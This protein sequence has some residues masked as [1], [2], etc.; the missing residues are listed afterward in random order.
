MQLSY[1][2]SIRTALLCL[3]LAS[4]EILVLPTSASAAK[5]CQ[6]LFRVAASEHA[7]IEFINSLTTGTALYGVVAKPKTFDG[8]GLYSRSVSGGWRRIVGGNVRVDDRGSH[9]LTQLALSK[10]TDHPLAVAVVDNRIVLFTPGPKI[11]STPSI[12]EFGSAETPLYEVGTWQKRFLQPSVPISMVSIVQSAGAS[13]HGAQLVSVSLKF[14]YPQS[15]GDGMTFAFEVPTKLVDRK[16]ILQGRPIVLDYEF[17][18]KADLARYHTGTN[19]N[20]VFSKI[21]LERA[22]AQDLTG[23][24][25]HFAKVSELLESYLKEIL[26]SI[27]GAKSSEKPD[28]AKLAYNITNGQI[29]ENV[30]FRQ[31]IWNA[32]TLRIDQ[33]YDPLKGTAR[34]QSNVAGITI[35]RTVDLYPDG[36]AAIWK[37]DQRNIAVIAGGSLF[38]FIHTSDGY[39]RHD[40]SPSFL[41]NFMGDTLP[42]DFSFIVHQPPPD[43]EGKTT[44]VKHGAIFV[45]FRTETA[46]GLTAMTSIVRFDRYGNSITNV[47]EPYT[48][49][50]NYLPIPMLRA[51][52]STQ[53]GGYVVFDKATPPAKTV[54]AYQQAYDPSKPH[55]SILES[56]VNDLRQRYNAPRAET[57]LGPRLTYAEFTPS[58]D[59]Q[60]PTGIYFGHGAKSQKITGNETERVLGSLLLNAAAAER[61][62]TPA[63]PP[64]EADFRLATIT[65]RWH[66]RDRS[67]GPEF[68]VLTSSQLGVYAIDAKRANGEY[69]YQLVVAIPPSPA[70]QTVYSLEFSRKDDFYPLEAYKDFQ[71]ASFIRGVRENRDLYYLLLVFKKSDGREATYIVPFNMAL[72]KQELKPVM[73]QARALS[74]AELRESVGF[75]ETGMPVILLTPDLAA[76]SQQFAI[77]DLRDERRILPNVERVGRYKNVKFGEWTSAE[78]QGQ[79]VYVK[80]EDSWMPVADVL[81]KEWPYLGRSSAMSANFEAFNDLAARLEAMADP[82]Q[83]ARRFILVVPQALR[84]LIWNFVL[85]RGVPLLARKATP[86]NPSYTPVTDR[87]FSDD[88]RFVD[89]SV[90]LKD[91]GHQHQ[92]LANLAY[93]EKQARRHPDVRQ[94]ALFRADDLGNAEYQ[95]APGN[96][97]FTVQTVSGAGEGLNVSTSTEERAPHPLYLVAAGGPVSL[98][99]FRAD[100]PAAKTS[101]F[102]LATPEDMQR[103]NSQ[104]QVEIENGLLKAFEIREI[105]DPDYP[106]MSNS[107]QQI[108]A[109]P[110]IAEME[111]S[112][113]A[114]EIKIGVDLDQ[115]ASR[116]SVIDFAVSRFSAL[117]KERKSSLFEDFMRFRRDFA[118]ALLS[119]KEVRSTR[120]INKFFIERVLSQVFNIPM[121]L[122]ALPPDDPLKVMAAPDALLRLQDAGYAG[123]FPLKARA[124]NVI[125]AQTRPDTG[126][127]MPSSMMIWGETGSGKTFLFQSIVAMLKLKVYD[128]HDDRS[129]ETAQA[130]HINVGKLADGANKEGNNSDN[131]T[132]DQAIEHLEQF[133]SGPMGYRGFILID[134]VHASSN[135]VKG[136][137]LNWIRTLQEAPDGMYTTASGVKRPVRNIVLMLTFNP[138]ANQKQIASFAKDKERP[139]EEEIL[140]ATLSSEEFPIEGSFLRRWGMVKHFDHMPAG[141]KG[142]ELIKKLGEQAGTLLNAIGRIGLVA[143]EMIQQLV[144]HNETV[145][146]RSFLAAS[147]GTLLEVAASDQRPGNLLMIVPKQGLFWNRVRPESG[148]G[149]TRISDTNPAERIQDWVKENS[150]ILVLDSGVEGRLMFTRLIANSYR[151]PIY[152]SLA[153][154]LQE[155]PRFASNTRVENSVTAPVLLAIR[156]HLHISNDISVSD[157]G[158]YAGQFGL[159]TRAES[160]YFREIVREL[161]GPRRDLIPKFLRSIEGATSMADD[162]GS[163]T[164]VHSRGRSDLLAEGF[165]KNRAILHRRLSQLLRMQDIDARPNPATWLDGLSEQTAFNHR[166]AGRELVQVLWDYLNDAFSGKLAVNAEEVQLDPYAA[167]RLFLYTLDQAVLAMPWAPT[168]QFLLDALAIVSRDQV[169]SQRPGV[170]AFLFSDKQRLVTAT[171]SDYAF[172]ILDSTE[173]IDRIPEATQVDMEKYFADNID[174][175]VRAKR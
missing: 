33:Y 81:R 139:T 104:A 97:L 94:V 54:P 8:E 95:K 109:L 145:D 80:S 75:D 5:A 110:D 44:L 92:I 20:I 34:I 28:E 14:K 60:D 140:L 147:A 32:G 39:M 164:R 112:F 13:K 119:D 11:D 9:L 65:H 155:D 118:L 43:K 23:F 137:I 57:P 61:E 26:K 53:T 132:A 93:F 143:P 48:V 142:P 68:E 158:F 173:I 102:V 174:R 37:D 76:D 129:A 133:L 74:Q 83:P 149:G 138:T 73:V 29:V 126:K 151:I 67:R 19:E 78:S 47:L 172:Q 127:Q 106:A 1:G 24:G 134:D 111:F 86:G 114:K 130:I 35:D 31:T 165:H 16:L 136:K 40:V 89:I 69:G 167:T 160:E 103:L 162:I 50:P 82:S 21:L 49:M 131:M 91:R 96:E 6:G 51:R 79:E 125:L 59:S 84:E 98:R 55:I 36:K 85:T 2:K 157:F 3:A 146:A 113:G 56:S 148:G 64:A 120:V 22:A 17:H 115:A 175:Y 161:S 152:E 124:R 105:K 171:L 63:Q 135:K 87:F 38:V 168:S 154:A 15:T 18:P 25:A 159:K 163:R 170:Q 77:F 90:F 10:V 128:F 108:F 153:M 70:Q 41:K 116:Q 88:H 71:F 62:F 101:V 58:N 27:S 42:T 117:Q 121:N 46:D 122:A 107:I 99:E 150:R 12:L 144:F 52:V 72:K 169:M 123:P 156:D 66:E 7:D 100:P 141:A 166:T 30:S 4:F 45:S